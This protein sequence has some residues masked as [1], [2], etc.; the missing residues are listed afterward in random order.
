MSKQI[1]LEIAL[2]LFAV[3]LVVFVQVVFLGASISQVLS[4]P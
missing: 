1:A 4:T 2:I 3:G